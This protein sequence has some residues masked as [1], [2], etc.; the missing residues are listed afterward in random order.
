MGILTALI[1]HRRFQPQTMR[2]HGVCGIPYDADFDE[3]RELA[4]VFNQKLRELIA[5]D[6]EDK[7]VNTESKP[8]HWNVA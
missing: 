8:Q 4:N 5:Q 1:I 2:F 6:F 3:Q 7:Y